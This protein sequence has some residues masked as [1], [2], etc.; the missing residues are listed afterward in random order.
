M[1][2][3]Q[4]QKMEKFPQKKTRNGHERP[5]KKT[6]KKTRQNAHVYGDVIVFNV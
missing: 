5:G 1:F 4:N 3:G 6:R 2:W